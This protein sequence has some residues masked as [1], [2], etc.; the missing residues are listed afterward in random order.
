MR[1]RMKGSGFQVQGAEFVFSFGVRFSVRAELCGTPN[2]NSEERTE[3]EREREHEPGSLN[4][5]PGTFLHSHLVNRSLFR[6]RSPTG[7]TVASGSNAPRS[8]ENRRCRAATW[9]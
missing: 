8:H 5:E 2:L 4:A 3:P 7:V 1:R 6:S 9:R